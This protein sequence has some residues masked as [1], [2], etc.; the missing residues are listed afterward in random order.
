M[1]VVAAAGIT[2]QLSVRLG[3]TLKDGACSI[4][5]EG[6]IGLQWT[7]AGCSAWLGYS[8]RYIVGRRCKKLLRLAGMAIEIMFTGE[9]RR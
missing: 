4:D 1:S 3:M 5:I 6:R 2:W 7:V 9:A 8:V